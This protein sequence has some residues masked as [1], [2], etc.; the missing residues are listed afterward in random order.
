[1]GEMKNET[2]RQVTSPADVVGWFH[3]AARKKGSNIPSADSGYIIQISE[4]VTHYANEIGR[5]Y[6]AEE[7]ANLEM[8]QLKFREVTNLVSK[9]DE[10][11]DHLRLY[12]SKQF[13]EKIY[14]I[15]VIDDLKKVIESKW[16]ENGLHAG[17][18]NPPL[19]YIWTRDLREPIVFA[20]R[21][22]GYDYSSN[23]ANNPTMR[24]LRRALAAI[25]GNERDEKSIEQA[26]RRWE[27]AWFPR[28]TKKPARS[29]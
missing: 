28:R 11:L 4:I 18:F 25:D 10:Q 1:M 14:L 7:I 29:A 21:Q 3:D 27:S 2:A 9:L 26:M 13:D 20:W 15:E 5:D 12:A 17:A 24:V 8:F 6:T 23:N 19:W 22:A 16:I